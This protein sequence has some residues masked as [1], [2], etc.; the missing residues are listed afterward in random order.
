MAKVGVIMLNNTTSKAEKEN[1]LGEG[2][3]W[4]C[5]NLVIMRK[6]RV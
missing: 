2:W 3:Q 5:S 6:E 1:K 4:R